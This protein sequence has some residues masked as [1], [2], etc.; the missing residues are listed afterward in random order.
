M[1]GVEDEAVAAAKRL[2]DSCADILHTTLVSAILHGSLTMDDFRP[3]RSD[4]DLLLV[5]ERGLTSGETDALVGA[6]GA[7]DPLLIGVELA[8]SERTTSHAPRI[9]PRE[10]EKVLLRVLDDL[11]EDTQE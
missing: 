8:L 11:G 7:A 5:V 9:A 10:I 2:A 4:L 1:S 3:G 6:V